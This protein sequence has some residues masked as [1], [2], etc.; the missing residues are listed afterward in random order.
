[1]GRWVVVSKRKGV[2][3]ERDFAPLNYIELRFLNAVR[4]YRYCQN[5]ARPSSSS[6]QKLLPLP[7]TFRQAYPGS[8]VNAPV[9][10]AVLRDVLTTLEGVSLLA[11]PDVSRL[12]ISAQRN[13]WSRAVRR[14]KAYALASTPTSTASI[15][16]SPVSSSIPLSLFQ[17][18]FV[19]EGNEGTSELVVL[20]TWQYGP[21]STRS[22]FESLWSHLARKVGDRLNELGFI[23]QEHKI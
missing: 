20:S 2:R 17:C 7:N 18:T 19:S 23:S 10:L 12:A 15:A 14:K 16:N 4:T 13:T 6:T 3:R 11:H 8:P 1:M 21:S 9:V 22:D 5:L